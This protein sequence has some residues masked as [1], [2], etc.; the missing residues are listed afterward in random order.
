[1]A[2]QRADIDRGRAGQTAEPSA[3]LLRKQR[4]NGAQPLGFVRIEGRLAVDP[5]RLFGD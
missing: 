1:M 4:R 5:R 2:P 3:L